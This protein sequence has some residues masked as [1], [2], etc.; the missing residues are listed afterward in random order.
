MQVTAGGAS[1]FLPI[2]TFQVTGSSL[3]QGLGMMAAPGTD[4]DDDPEVAEVATC[5]SGAP[6]LG[7]LTQKVTTNGL[8]LED[9]V[10]GR[11]RVA[12]KSG[13]K[14]TISRPGAGVTVEIECAPSIAYNTA[15]PTDPDD[16]YLLVTSGT[17][18]VSSAAHNA[19]LSYQAG[20][21][22]VA[23]TG[24]M[25][26]AYVNRKMTPRTTGNIR[27]EIVFTD[28]YISA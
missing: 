19:K 7:L 15:Q 8:V 23:Q 25:V 13:E 16:G 1:D 21:L 2:G 10:L 4:A 22:R 6:F 5:T 26:V 9:V 27:L 12:A 14:V 24:D 17:G 18:D 11:G 20:R 28:N 3:P